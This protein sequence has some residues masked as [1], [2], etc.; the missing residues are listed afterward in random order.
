MIN[1]TLTLF[2]DLRLQF[3]AITHFSPEEKMVARTVLESL[4]LKHDANRWSTS[5][6]Q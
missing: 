1:S 4:I 5:S 3:E 2:I 6:G